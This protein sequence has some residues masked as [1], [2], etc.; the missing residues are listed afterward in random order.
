MG[1]DFWYLR[2]CP[3]EDVWRRLLLPRLE[4]THESQRDQSHMLKLSICRSVCKYKALGAKSNKKKKKSFPI[5]WRILLG[6]V[7]LNYPF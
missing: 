1:S 4:V 2:P 3:F 6:I 5:Y 7:T